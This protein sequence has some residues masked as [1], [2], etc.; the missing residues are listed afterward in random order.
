MLLRSASDGS[1]CLM[2][3]TFKQGAAALGFIS[4][5]HDSENGK[6]NTYPAIYF[7]RWRSRMSWWFVMANLAGG[8]NDQVLAQIDCTT[9]IN[10]AQWNMHVLDAGFDSFPGWLE[11]RT[12]CINILQHPSRWMEKVRAEVPFEVPFALQ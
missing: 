3:W 12:G 1:Y 6:P 9:K 5:G 8:A 4:R 2:T 10:Q 11:R 7:K